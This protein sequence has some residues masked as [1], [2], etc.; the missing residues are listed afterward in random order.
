METYKKLSEKFGGGLKELALLLEQEHKGANLSDLYKFVAV[1]DGNMNVLK[2]LLNSDVAAEHLTY[3]GLTGY[4]QIRSGFGP[5]APLLSKIIKLDPTQVE[6]DEIAHFITTEPD[7]QGFNES[8]SHSRDSD[9]RS[10]SDERNNSLERANS[11]EQ[12]DSFRQTES[13]VQKRSEFVEK[14]LAEGVRADKLNE[15]YLDGR[16]DLQNELGAGFPAMQ[17]LIKLDKRGDI[18]FANMDYQFE[19]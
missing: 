15:R 12:T 7:R 14:L 17:R 19:K 1:D 13:G 6:L 2:E 16:F 3:R 18:S 11:G 10:N 8:K 5:D 4:A 9:E